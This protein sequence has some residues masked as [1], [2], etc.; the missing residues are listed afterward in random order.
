MSAAS[1]D[2]RDRA[3]V[4]KRLEAELFD[5]VV[6]GGGVTGA[7]VARDAAERGLSVAL[8]DAGDYA[9]GT[10]SRSSKMIHGGLRYLAQGDT[11]L[12]KE[13]A[14]ERQVLRRIAPHLTRYAPFLVP[15]PSLASVAKLRAGLWLF[16][17]LG[18][19]RAEERHE[20]WSAAE[21]AEREP[22]LKTDHLAAAAVYPEFLTDD[23]RLTLA[24]VRAAA[25]AGAAVL[26][27]AEVTNMFGAQAAEGVVCRS[28][29]PGE[30]AGARVRARTVVNAAGPWVDAVRALEAGDAAP[31]LSLTK[32]VHVVVPHARAPV[33]RTVILRTED[34][35][36]VFAVP[37]DGL[38]YFGTTDTFYPGAEVW[39]PITEEDVTY[40]FRAAE[41]TL[42]I[43][44]L[45]LSDV[46]AAWSGVRPL[47]AEAGKSAGEIS[48]KDEIWIGPKGV[49]TIAGGKLSAYRAMAERITDLILQHLGRPSTPSRTATTP[50]PG[51]NYD[52]EAL[53]RRLAGLGERAGRLVE[54]YGAE[55]EDLAAE[56][57][58]V[59]AE[60]RR[61]VQHEGAVRLED[62]WVRRSTR[63]WFTADGGLG[64]L[65]PAAAAMG[66]LL[67][68][69]E[70]RRS[71]E[72]AACIALRHATL[73]FP[74]HSGAAA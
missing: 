25:A 20:L 70:D 56:G 7:G 44:P 53:S 55:A 52:A 23:A 12:V 60:A 10:S 18:Q 16:E 29:A 17:K 31:R 46:T 11:G 24:N 48:R 57:G 22:L 38:T 69:T 49:V 14:S 73:S 26:N 64:A 74:A 39:P 5:L 72:I 2:T 45:S 59:A 63:F 33:G 35:R 42:K 34:K 40:L 62:Y 15:A 66:A 65:E 4:F 61:A 30:T 37:R 21:V 8:L 28:T 41:R 1:I 9:R 50:L 47:I 3:A 71:S 13:A 67:G 54:L 6:I 27:Y 43:E 58:D 32:G 68:W 36:S 51:G 19:A